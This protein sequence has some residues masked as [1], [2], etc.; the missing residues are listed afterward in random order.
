MKIVEIEGE[1]GKEYW[2]YDRELGLGKLDTEKGPD[3]RKNLS[4]KTSEI[5]E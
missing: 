4:A 2:L 5:F 3:W 1:K